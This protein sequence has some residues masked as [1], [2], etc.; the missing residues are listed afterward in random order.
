VL[1]EMGNSLLVSKFI[2][3]SHIQ[4]KPTV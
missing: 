2:T 3:A 1:P 4:N